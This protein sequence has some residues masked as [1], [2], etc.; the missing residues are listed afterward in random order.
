MAIQHRRGNEADFMPGRMLPG[1]Y[2]FSVDEQRVHATFA[3][4]Q[5]KT[6]A[7]REDFD[8]I[9]EQGI[10]EATQE[11][12]AWAHGNSF[13]EYQHNADGTPIMPG[14]V[15]DTSTD[16]AK[17]Y[18]ELAEA[19]ADDS[20]ISE[21][22]ALTSETNARTSENNA[23]ASATRAGTSETNAAN[24]AAQAAASAEEARRV[25]DGKLSREFVNSLPTTGI[26]ENTIYIVPNS[27]PKYQNTKKEYIWD[28]NA[29]DWELWGDST[30]DVSPNSQLVDGIVTKGQNQNR[31]VWGTDAN[32][33]PA[34]RDTQIKHLTTAEYN[35]LPAT[36]RNN[37]AFYVTDD[38]QG[39]SFTDVYN[40]LNLLSPLAVE[41][42]ES[43]AISRAANE[44]ATQ[45]VNIGKEGHMPIGILGWYI[46]AVGTAN[47]IRLEDIRITSST[48]AEVRYTN[49]ATAQNVSVRLDVLY[50]S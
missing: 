27:D 43:E 38:N 16:N 20:A 3:P 34:W 8:G 49:N 21:Q 42:K 46:N 22:N 11:A 33:N 28:S 44:F 2:G 24:S 15:H 7:F 29:N 36:E 23:S 6:V 41:T 18:S 9:V 19:S 10:S 5:C 26:K 40:R 4:G 39:Y 47:G 13:V 1:E 45:T 30:I 31:K 48:T 32:G 12:E 35:A 37:G 17:Y 25:V 50:I 14:V